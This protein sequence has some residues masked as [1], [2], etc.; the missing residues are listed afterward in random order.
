MLV[1]NSGGVK[2]LTAEL[3]GL[4]KLQG[5]V[6]CPMDDGSEI[7]ASFEYPHSAPVE[8]SVALTGCR[9]VSNRRL[10]RTADSATGSR[11]VDQLISL[12]R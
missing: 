3:D 8:I 5:R 7:A 1:T 9:M 6:P 2:R 12:L 4:P 10:T 11:L